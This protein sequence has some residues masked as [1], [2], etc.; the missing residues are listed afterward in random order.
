MGTAEP[1]YP[2]TACDHHRKLYFEVVN[3]LTSSVKE[4]FNQPSFKMYASLETLLLKA[5]NG[6][7]I[8]KDVDNSASKYSGDVNVNSVV[9]Q[10]STFYVLTTGV[11]L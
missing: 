1:T 9:A 5:A 10:L 7:Y 3:D 4:R 6:E 8:S 2:S 11:R